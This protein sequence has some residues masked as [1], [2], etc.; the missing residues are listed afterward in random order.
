SEDFLELPTSSMIFTTATGSPLSG[1]GRSFADRVLLEPGAE[2]KRN[3]RKASAGGGWAPAAGP[4]HAPRGALSQC[5]ALPAAARRRG[6]WCGCGLLEELL[7]CGRN[8]GGFLLGGGGG[9]GHLDLRPRRAVLAVA[10]GH[11]ANVLRGP[12]AEPFQPSARHWR[13]NL[14]QDS[15]LLVG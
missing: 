7:K 2:G 14:G 1:R 3:L 11:D 9:H 8:R 5:C 4:D 10:T 12:R 13:R 6:L 15:R